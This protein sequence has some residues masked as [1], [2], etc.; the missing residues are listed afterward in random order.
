MV[1]PRW[2]LEPFGGVRASAST[3]GHGGFK[4]FHGDPIS[5]P[6]PQLRNSSGRVLPLPEG[7]VMPLGR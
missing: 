2:D 6:D 1:A 7:A 3:A 4:F 5:D